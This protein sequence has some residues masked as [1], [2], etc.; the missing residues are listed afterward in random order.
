MFAMR[1]KKPRQTVFQMRTDTAEGQE[2]L[3]ALD[4]LRTDERPQLD[5]TAMLKKLTFDAHKRL[6]RR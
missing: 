6:K 1:Q 3:A 5:R 4:E 2:F